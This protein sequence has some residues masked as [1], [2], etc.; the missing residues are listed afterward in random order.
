MAAGSPLSSFSSVSS[1]RIR[2]RKAKVLSFDVAF[3]MHLSGH[4]LSGS[5]LTL[6]SKQRHLATFRL[7]PGLVP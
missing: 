6:K 7:A 1:L 2:D 3:S 4:F 5:S